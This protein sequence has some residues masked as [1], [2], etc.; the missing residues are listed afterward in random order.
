[1]NIKK[2][3][4]TC[5]ACGKENTWV[6]SNESRPFCSP[7]CKLIDLGAWAAEAH[8]IPGN[9]AMDASADDNEDDEN[10]RNT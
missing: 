5:P 2:T 8:R 4:I 10:E 6:N 7:R 1:M 9:P 3:A